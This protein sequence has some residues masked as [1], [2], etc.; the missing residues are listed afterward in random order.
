MAHV[1]HERK[2]REN[3]HL[4]GDRRDLP[5]NLCMAWCGAN[6]NGEWFYL[7]ADHAAMAAQQMSGPPICD[8]CKVEIV[9]AL[10][11]LGAEP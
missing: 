4:V 5:D 6:A 1:R 8:E 10:S 2:T 11:A 7:G 3:A 9:A